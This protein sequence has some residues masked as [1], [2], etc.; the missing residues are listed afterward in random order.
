MIHTHKFFLW[1]HR[2]DKRLWLS[3]PTESGG[4]HFQDSLDTKHDPAVIFDDDDDDEK[5][6]NM[7]SFQKFCQ[8]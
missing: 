4:S 7:N 5:C 3:V 2:D 6:K 1:S 8:K